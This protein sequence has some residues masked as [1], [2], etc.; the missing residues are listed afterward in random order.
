MDLVC[1]LQCCHILRMPAACMGRRTLST[2]YM[3]GFW[4][5][6]F[7]MDLF[8]TWCAVIWCSCHSTTNKKPTPC[9]AMEPAE[10][11]QWVCLPW[12]VVKGTFLQAWRAYISSAKPNLPA[13]LKCVS[14]NDILTVRLR[15]SFFIEYRRDVGLPL[16]LQYISCFFLCSIGFLLPLVETKDMVYCWCRAPLWFVINLPIYQ[17]KLK[18]A[19][20]W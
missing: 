3:H 19:K 11:F 12:K 7:P 9:L 15:N 5:V 6:K 8:W 13:L 18:K 1:I 16:L 4:R 17:V 2:S 10:V 14:Y 20:R